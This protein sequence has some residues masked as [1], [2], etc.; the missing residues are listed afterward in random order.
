MVEIYSTKRTKDDSNDRH[1]RPQGRRIDGERINKGSLT[2]LTREL[3]RGD[4]VG[5]V[6]VLDAL[7]EVPG[8]RRLVGP[9]EEARR[10]LLEGVELGLDV[11]PDHGDQRGPPLVGIVTLALAAV[12]RT[13]GAGRAGDAVGIDAGVSGGRE[14]PDEDGHD[15]VGRLEVLA[16]AAGLLDVL[17]LRQGLVLGHKDLV[18]MAVHAE[19]TVGL[20]LGREVGPG[21]GAS[22]GIVHDNLHVFMSIGNTALC[23]CIVL[24]NEFLSFLFYKMFEAVNF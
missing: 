19:A 20:Q 15:G 23:T 24:L 12:A 2:A 17:F 7:D 10:V 3:P 14:F 8:A 6:A 1:E 22:E 9:H 13:G 11:L 21:P 16:P 4:G 5:N 18:Q